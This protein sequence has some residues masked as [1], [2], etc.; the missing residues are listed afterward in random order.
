MVLFSVVREFLVLKSFLPSAIRLKSCR[1]FSRNFNMTKKNQ[2]DTFPQKNTF[3]LAMNEVELPTVPTIDTYDLPFFN[4]SAKRFETLVRH[5]TPFICIFT[6]LFRKWGR[7]P[8][9]Q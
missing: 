6:P 3:T 4:S 5:L 8:F 7:T 1:Y 9:S 2:K